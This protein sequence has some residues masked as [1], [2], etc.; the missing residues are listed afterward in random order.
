MAEKTH[1]NPFLLI[2]AGKKMLYVFAV[3]FVPLLLHKTLPPS[4]PDGTASTGGQGTAHVN[5]KGQQRL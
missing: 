3:T 1:G 4:S 5:S 2:L